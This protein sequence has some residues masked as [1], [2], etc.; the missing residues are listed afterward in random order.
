MKLRTFIVTVKIRRDIKHD[1]RNKVTGTCPVSSMCTDL[2][3]AHHSYLTTGFSVSEVLEMARLNGWE[4]VTR[5]EEV[6]TL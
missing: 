1:P 6:S 3:G 4:H 2:T 5:V